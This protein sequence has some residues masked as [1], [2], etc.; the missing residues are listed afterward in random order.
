MRLINSPAGALNLDVQKKLHKKTVWKT[1]Q[2]VSWIINNLTDKW[3]HPFE[4]KLIAPMIYHRIKNDWS[5]I[6]N[7]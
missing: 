5:L 2:Q 1:A 6:W 7:K 4:A 3:T